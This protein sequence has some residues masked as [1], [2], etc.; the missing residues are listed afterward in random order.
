M[1]KLITILTLAVL[2]L[3]VSTLAQPDDDRG[4]RDRPSPREHG[5]RD[6]RP[7]DR[8]RPSDRFRPGDRERDGER[9]SDRQRSSQREPIAV[10]QIPQA[11]A[12]L[13]DMHSEP[14]PTWIE[15]I[16][17]MAEEDPE[18]AA[19]KLSRFPRLSEL[20][21]MREQRPEE[22]QLHAGQSKL[23][24][25]IFKLIREIREAQRNEDQARVDELK[26]RLREKM[27]AAFDFRMKIKQ[28]EIERDRQKLADA[29]RE[30]AEIRADRD[31]LIDQKLE[32]MLT[33]GTGLHGP[34]EDGDRPERPGRDRPDRPDR[35]GPPPDR[36][37]RE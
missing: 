6:G 7:G 9:G 11:I 24:R 14:Y 12:T 1:N 18:D 22:F 16:E 30:L 17:T 4:P 36:P 25:E 15:R 20:M 35:E 32:E 3:P 34:R 31:A 23:M 33:R 13:R 10:E 29:E 8:E 21:K 37:E 28:I 19:R 5:D 26:P 27:E 2:A